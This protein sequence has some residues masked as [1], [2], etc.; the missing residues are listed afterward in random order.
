M[1]ESNKTHISNISTSVARFGDYLKEAF[2][3]VDE[4]LK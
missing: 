1:L 2:G 4:N 3:N